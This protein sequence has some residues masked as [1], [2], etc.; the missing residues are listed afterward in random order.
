MDM[1]TS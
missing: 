1:K